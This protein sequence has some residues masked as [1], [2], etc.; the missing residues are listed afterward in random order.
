MNVSGC[1]WVGHTSD[2]MLF[3]DFLV[4]Y[5]AV[6][7]P[8]ARLQTKETTFLRSECNSVYLISVVQDPVLGLRAACRH[9]G[10][11][12]QTDKSALNYK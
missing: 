3:I 8:W 5:Q 2:L 10:S 7:G 11:H 12:F 6:S 1:S 9:C 4:M